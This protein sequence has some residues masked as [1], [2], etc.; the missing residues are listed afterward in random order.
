MRT[1]ILLTF[2]LAGCGDKDDTG[3]R[4]CTDPDLDGDGFAAEA[5]GGTDC[6]DADAEVWYGADDPFGDGIDQSCDGVDGVDMDGDGWAR[7]DDGGEDCDDADSSVHPDA[8]DLVGDDLD[9]NCDGIDGVD[10][11]QDGYASAASGGNDC[12]D[13]DPDINP[14]A[15]DGGNPGNEAVADFWSAGGTRIGVDDGGAVHMIIGEIYQSGSSVKCRLVYATDASGVW[16]TSSVGS[17]TGTSGCPFDAAFEPD[18]TA[19]AAW[20]GSGLIYASNASG[21]FVQQTVAADAPT[22]NLARVALDSGDPVLAWRDDAER[23]QISEPGE[24]G[25]TTTEVGGHQ[26]F[27]LL[28]FAIDDSG[29]RHVVLLQGSALVHASDAGGW[30]P[31]TIA[32]DAANDGLGLVV[33]ASGAP[34]VAYF[35]GE[36]LCHADSTGSTQIIDGIDGADGAT[37]TRDTDGGLHVAWSYSYYGSALE[38][39]ALPAAASSWTTVTLVPDAGRY[40]SAAVA[41]DGWIHFGHVDGGDIQ[42]AWLSLPDGIDDDCD[43]EAW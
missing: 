6:D 40:P 2:A 16:E 27:D 26:D 33:D 18:G 30:A 12:D 41:R 37:I 1:L 17:I 9:A 35:C 25:W 36:A 7:D 4:D 29:D 22:Y 21:S 20:S 34:Q 5:C 43:G 13:A 8:D 14:G 3:T 24:D 19:H 38:Y 15:S 10:A 39:A 32:S 42:H 31:S 28:A 11:D 23:L